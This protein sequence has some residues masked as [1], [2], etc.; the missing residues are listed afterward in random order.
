[1]DASGNGG[2]APVLTKEEL[3]DLPCSKFEV[4]E[5]HDEGDVFFKCTVCQ[6][7]FEDRARIRTLRCL[8]MFH[9]KCID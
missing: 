5:E 8:H 2:R 9:K 4:T 6:M 7:D 1:M 3:K